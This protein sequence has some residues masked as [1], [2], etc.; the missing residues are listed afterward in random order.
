[1][2]FIVFCSKP[3]LS[4]VNLNFLFVCRGSRKR[5]ATL[6]PFSSRAVD[7]ET[8][9]G[10]VRVRV[11]PRYVHVGTKLD[12]SGQVR[13]AVMANLSSAKSA[14]SSNRPFL[15]SNSL[16]DKPRSVA[17][18]S[19]VLSHLFYNCGLWPHLPLPFFPMLMVPTV[20]FG[21]VCMATML[22]WYYP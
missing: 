20:S 2:Y 11:N 17:L 21:I 22:V 10:N 3:I 16:Q 1:M 9:F 13:P 15:V 4:L 8:V 7:A 12:I 19:L 18:R 14:F 5:L 6:G